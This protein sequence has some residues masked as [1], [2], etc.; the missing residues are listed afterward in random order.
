[1]DLVFYNRLL[2]CYVLIDLKTGKLKHQDIGQMQMYVHYFDRYVKTHDENPTVGILLCQE[3]NDA[4]VELTLPEGENIY[5][6]E[7]S[8]YLPDKGLLQ[9]KLVEWIEEFEEA[10]DALEAANGGKQ[11]EV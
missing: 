7:Y 11:K 10:Q 8:L 6:S 9:Q 2:K 4:V 5:A 3:K 1:V